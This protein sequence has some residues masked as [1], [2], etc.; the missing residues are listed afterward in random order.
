MVY[1]KVNLD[2]ENSRK[3]EALTEAERDTFDDLASYSDDH[4]DGFDLFCNQ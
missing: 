2:L 3:W 4:Y 1:H